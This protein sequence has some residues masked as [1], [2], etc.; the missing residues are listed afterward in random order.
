MF[1]GQRSTKANHQVSRPLDKVAV[2]ANAVLGLQIE[3]QAHVDASVPEVSVERAAI[4]V[5]VHQL[6]KIAQV[7]S[8][9]FRRD[10]RIVPPFPV[11]RHS[12]R[13][14]RCTGP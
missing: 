10:G 6:P 9:L 1:A 11:Q 12:R 13:K 4:F 5:F 14:R 8:Q 7:R 3:I 2:F